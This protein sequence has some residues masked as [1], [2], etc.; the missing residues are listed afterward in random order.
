[1]LDAS[2]TLLP[3]AVRTPVTG[4]FTLSLPAPG[5]YRLLVDA[6]D[7]HVPTLPQFLFTVKAGTQDLTVKLPPVL[8]AVPTGTEIHWV[9]RTAPLH[10]RTA[11]VSTPGKAAPF[12]GPLDQLLALW[13]RPTPDTLVLWDGKI[14]LPHPLRSVYLQSPVTPGITNFSVLPL[15]PGFPPANPGKLPS[16]LHGEVSQQITCYAGIPTRCDVWP[17]TYAIT[18]WNNEFLGTLDVPDGGP[19]GMPLAIDLTQRM[20]LRRP[21]YENKMTL[22]FSRVDY[23]AWRKL[24]SEP[25]VFTD[26]GEQLF[27]QWNKTDEQ[28]MIYNIPTAAHALSIGWLG[29]GV[30]RD[31]PVR[32][33]MTLPA[34]AA[35]AT[36]SGKVLR[37]NGN[38]GPEFDHMLLRVDFDEPWLADVGFGACFTQPLRLLPDVEQLEGEDRYRLVSSGEEWELLAGAARANDV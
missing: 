10:E 33:E 4:T 20:P 7:E 9:T 29:A 17:G 21:V 31:I 14:M 28:G 30:L 16:T 32:P 12:F 5:A 24:G 11:I 38:A 1:V 6:Y 8:V 25:T 27:L 19:D 36:I 35:G 3:D 23:D 34:W 2:G 18:L 26:T 37:K 13:Y 15:L 22:S